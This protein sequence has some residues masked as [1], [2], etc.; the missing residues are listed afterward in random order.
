MRKEKLD[1]LKGYINELKTIKKIPR[2]QEV[3]CD[4]NE[5]IK[6]KGF[7]QIESYDCYLNNGRVIP[8]EK[9]L[10]KGSNGDAA[11]VLP[12]TRDGNTLLVV[13]PRPNTKETVGV[14]F[15]AGYVEDGED[16]IVSGERELLEET[17]YAPREMIFLDSYYQ[18]Q[19]CYGA[20]NHS[21]L[22]LGCEKIKKQQLDKDEII[23]YF[24]CRYEEVEELIKMNFISDVNSKYAFSKAK[25]YIKNNKVRGVFYE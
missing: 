22:A 9:V 18:D 10:K 23:R 6:S 20:Y 25:Q 4:S 2:E 14:E 16:P 24:E 7:L 8:R 1:E 5:K 21:Y 15:P 17:G 12:I 13:Q 19:G 3:I 11:I